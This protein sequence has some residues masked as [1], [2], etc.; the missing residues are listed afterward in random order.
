MLQAG[1]LRRALA[2]YLGEAFRAS[3]ARDLAA[4]PPASW[5]RNEKW[6]HVGCFDS[7]G[8][9]LDC[10]AG[11]LIAVARL[12]LSVQRADFSQ[13]TGL[14]ADAAHGRA[15]AEPASPAQRDV[16]RA[17]KRELVLGRQVAPA[18]DWLEWSLEMR[19]ALT[20]RGRV[21]NVFLPRRISGTLAVPPTTRPERLLRYDLH[22]RSRPWLPEIEGMLAGGGFAGS[23]LDEPAGRTA[24][25]LLGALVAYCE[26][27]IA[28]A[29]KQWTTD[30]VGVVAPVRR[31]LLPSQPG[32][33]FTGVAPGGTTPIQG[34][35]GAINEEH[36]SLAEQLRLRRLANGPRQP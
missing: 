16:W 2:A 10:L 33:K 29:N 34:A 35:I 7:F 24:R 32:I 31:W 4:R 8:T 25:G 5:H 1:H 17:L 26:Q 30:V 18:P 13:L 15:F 11:V 23:W 36:L 27:L 12:P 19:N 22:L 14:D 20:H 9:A 3:P 28:W 21:T 6:L